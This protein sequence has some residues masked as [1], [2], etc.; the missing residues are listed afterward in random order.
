MTSVRK[1]KGTQIGRSSILNICMG[2][3]NRGVQMFMLRHQKQK[4]CKAGWVGGNKNTTFVVGNV[5]WT[6]QIGELKLTFLRAD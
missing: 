2:S 5:D 6:T 1:Q 4:N 3:K